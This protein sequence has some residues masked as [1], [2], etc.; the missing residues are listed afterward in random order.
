MKKKIDIKP[1]IAELEQAKEGSRKLDNAIESLMPFPKPTNPDEVVGYPPYYTTS[2]DA[3]LTLV[4]EGWS[5]MIEGGLSTQS[6]SAYLAHP[7]TE[8]FVQGIASP[9]ALA[10]CIAAL[11]A[12][13]AA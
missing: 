10:L 12:R 2:L 6:P 13:D 9:S 8:G 4:P 5:Y 3:A 7:E 1:L 11:K